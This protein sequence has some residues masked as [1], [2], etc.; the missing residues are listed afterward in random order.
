MKRF[1]AAAAIAA[2]LMVFAGTAQ[3]VTIYMTTNQGSDTAVGGT[4]FVNPDAV[5]LDLIGRRLAR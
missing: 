3:A 5:E 4:N 1:I 2:F